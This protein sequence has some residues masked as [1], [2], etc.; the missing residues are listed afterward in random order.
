MDKPQ[1]CMS[2]SSGGCKSEESRVLQAQHGWGLAF[3]PRSVCS[4]CPHAGGRGECSGAIALRVDF[5][6]GLW[7]AQT[8]YSTHV[9]VATML[10]T[11]CA[12]F[13]IVADGRHSTNGS[14]HYCL[15]RNFATITLPEESSKCTSPSAGKCR[16]SLP[17]LAQALGSQL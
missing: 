3:H 14:S 2:H 1:K 12:R 5:S 13:H 17:G 9:A 4:L 15:H 6:A 10:F 7:R 11:Q 8:V 16:P